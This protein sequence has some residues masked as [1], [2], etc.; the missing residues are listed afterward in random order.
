LGAGGLCPC[1]WGLASP[2]DPSPGEQACSY[3]SLT[4]PV[5]CEGSDTVSDL[6]GTWAEWSVWSTGRAGAWQSVSVGV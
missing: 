6:E 3:C 5:L 4:S 1:W 2:P